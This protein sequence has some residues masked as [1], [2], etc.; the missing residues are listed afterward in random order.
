[1]SGGS[2]PSDMPTKHYRVA[3][4][5]LFAVIGIIMMLVTSCKQVFLFQLQIHFP[6]FKHSLNQALYLNFPTLTT[7]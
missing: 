3:F 4:I 1:M 6:I 5:Y 7:M 2:N